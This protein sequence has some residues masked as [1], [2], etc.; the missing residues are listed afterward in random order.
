[1]TRLFPA[2]GGR[3]AVTASPAVGARR[4]S[5]VVPFPPALHRGLRRDA[6]PVRTPPAAGDGTRPPREDRAPGDGGLPPLRLRE[7]RVVQRPVPA[8]VR[9]PSPDVPQGGR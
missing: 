2:S 9:V 1:M 8:A 3:P 5:L 4:V 7:P 6:A